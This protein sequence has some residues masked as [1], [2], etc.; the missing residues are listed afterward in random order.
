MK[1]TALKQCIILVFCFFLTSCLAITTEETTNTTSSPSTITTPT[2]LETTTTM[3]TT[4]PTTV[5]TTAVTTAITTVE[6]VYTSVKLYLREPRLT[7]F[8]PQMDFMTCKE[9]DIDYYFFNTIDPTLRDEFINYQL[10]L[11]SYL[12]SNQIIPDYNI[13]HYILVDYPSRSESARQKAY[14]DIDT[15]GS[16][17]QILITLQSYF[18]D[19]TNYGMLYGLS[20]YIANQLGW[21]T[22]IPTYSIGEIVTFTEVL[23]NQDNLDLTYPCFL[24]SYVGE[25]LP[26]IKAIA[27]RLMEYLINQEGIANVV[28]IMHRENASPMLFLTEANA[29][30]NEWLL[31]IG[32][33]TH[34]TAREVAIRFQCGGVTSPIIASTEHATY[35][36]LNDYSEADMDMMGIDYF[37]SDYAHMIEAFYMTELDMA[38]SDQMYKDPIRNYQA[39]SI[40]LCSEEATMAAANSIA[41]YSTASF[42]I[43][44]AS[45][46]PLNHEYLHY[47]TTPSYG[48]NWQYEAIAVYGN[49]DGYFLRKYYQALFEAMIQYNWNGLA[50]MQEYL[51]RDP[52]TDD[53][54]TYCDICITLNNENDVN[55]LN[56]YILSSIPNYVYITYGEEVMNQIFL[57]QDTIEAEI[58][59][60]WQGLIDE[61]NQW[62]IDTYGYLAE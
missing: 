10:A 19:Y 34:L 46:W 9:N 23:E 22:D 3:P 39:L 20:N 16:Y 32:S 40:V 36:L 13:K 43:Y 56:P 5:P 45:V 52:Q 1:K 41:Y 60:T 2:T 55:A 25:A 51:G 50:E 6:R 14:I 31:S 54:P 38:I 48:Y 44:S 29:I 61:W 35:Y 58:S 37:M 12:E 4:V 8:L 11:I 7:G 17:R 27:S 59:L 42:T 21:E 62:L 49:R 15:V 28:A 53:F 18:G 24:S 33:T 47:L 57:H 30:M 26:M